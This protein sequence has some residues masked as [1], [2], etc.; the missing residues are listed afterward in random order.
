MQDLPS[1]GCSEAM[2]LGHILIM[3]LQIGEVN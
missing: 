3:I 2:L 1:R